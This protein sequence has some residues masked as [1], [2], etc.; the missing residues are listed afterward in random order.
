MSGDHLLRE[1]GTFVLTGRKTASRR[2]E[3]GNEEQKMPL[4]ARCDRI[5]TRGVHLRNLR[6]RRARLRDLRLL[7]ETREADSHLRSRRVFGFAVRVYQGA[8]TALVDVPV[9]N[10]DWRE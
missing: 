4:I 6:A 9:F 7:F 2:R 3:D 5:T 8:E 1:A 10:P